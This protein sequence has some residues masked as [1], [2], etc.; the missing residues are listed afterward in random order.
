[1]PAH[2]IETPQRPVII[3]NDD[4]RFTQKVAHNVRALEC[5]FAAVRKEEPLL[6]E[7]TATL[8]FVDVRRKVKR[9]LQ[10]VARSLSSDQ[11]R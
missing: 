10:R 8:Y 5:D 3:A 2:V 6:C 9:L 11:G 7:P 1:M 4:Q